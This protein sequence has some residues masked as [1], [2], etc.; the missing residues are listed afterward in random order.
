MPKSV[1]VLDD[2]GTGGGAGGIISASISG[3]SLQSV[4]RF[5]WAAGA[6]LEARSPT[7]RV[8]LTA[9]R[10]GFTVGAGIEFGL[11]EN[12]SGKIEYDFY[13]FGSNRRPQLQI[14]LVGRPKP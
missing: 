4:T 5:G 9:N 3:G 12:L 8:L 13:D 10:T 6:G 7:A 14:Q 2:I 1:L 11:V